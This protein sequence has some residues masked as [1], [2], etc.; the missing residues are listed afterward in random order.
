MILYV[1]YLV[2][3]HLLIYKNSTF[4]P[5]SK[6][7]LTI[8]LTDKENAGNNILIQLCLIYLKLLF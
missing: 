4:I 1:I 8:E 3:N 7:G 5:T 2:I 6:N